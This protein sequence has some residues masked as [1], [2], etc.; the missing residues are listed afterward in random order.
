LIILSFKP[1]LKDLDTFVS[2]ALFSPNSNGICSLDPKLAFHEFTLIS[3]FWKNKKSFAW[4]NSFAR[5]KSIPYHEFSYW[6]LEMGGN[7]G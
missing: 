6:Y 5:G 1:D 2:L 3:L 4:C 7:G